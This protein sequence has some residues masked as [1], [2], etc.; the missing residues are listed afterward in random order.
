[1]ETNLVKVLC[2]FAYPVGHRLVQ[3]P[4]YGQKNKNCEVKLV[5]S[6]FYS[7][8]TIFWGFYPLL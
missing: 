4:L 3:R 6:H 8:N 1:M 2:C 5:R 7:N